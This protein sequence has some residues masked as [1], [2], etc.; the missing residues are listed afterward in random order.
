M[1]SEG[2]TEDLLLLV[3]LLR[4]LRHTDMT[5]QQYWLLR[6][7]RCSG[8]Q[9]IGELAQ[10]LGITTG[11]ATVACKRLEKAG[12][13][14]RTRQADDERVVQ[15]SLTDAG[16]VQIDTVR[17][18]RRESLNHLLQVLDQPEQ[19]ELQRLIE[20][21]LDAAETQGFGETN[22]NDTHH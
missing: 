9:S 14:T 7:L 19:Q 17:Q 12:L 21:L 10:A 22:K 5:P 8:S 6:H 20:R 11:S 2:L 1:A 13:I 16:R 3:R 15:V 18:Q 4:P